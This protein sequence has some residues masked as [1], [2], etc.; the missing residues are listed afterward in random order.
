MT[1]LLAA[2]GEHSAATS[3]DAAEP[4]GYTAFVDATPV[5]VRGYSGDAMEPFISK[6]GQSLY[7]NSGASV[8]H[9]SDLYYASRIDAVTFA[10]RGPVRGVNT[11]ALDAVPSVDA[12]GVFYFLSTSA[13]RG[14]SSLYRGQLRDGAIQTVSLAAVHDVSERVP[15]D[16]EISGDGNTLWLAVSHY[17]KGRP[18]D[19]DIVIAER[20]GRSF[21]LRKDSWG[22]MRSINTR[23][24]EYAPSISADGRELFFARLDETQPAALPAIYRAT[25]ADSRSPFDAGQRVMAATGDVGSPSLAADGRSLYFHKRTAAGFAIFRVNRP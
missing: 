12:A 17:T 22:I 19:V 23:A 8:G 10:F 18:D 24:R 1:A 15:L 9:G 13:E 6:D 25:R 20:V 21:V 5:T 14:R 4:R 7:F 2:C 11:D 3:H 16:A